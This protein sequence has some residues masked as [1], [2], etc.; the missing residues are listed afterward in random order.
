MITNN[1]ICTREI[2]SIIAVAEEGF[3]KRK[4][5]QTGR[6]FEEETNKMLHLEHCFE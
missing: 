6:I 1:A 2:N 4:I 3:G 5:Q